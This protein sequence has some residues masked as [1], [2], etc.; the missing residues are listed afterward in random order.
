MDGII[1][2]VCNALKK[3]RIAR[4]MTEYERL[5]SGAATLAEAERFTGGGGDRYRSQSCRFEVVRSPADEPG[6]W[7]DDDGRAPPDGIPDEPFHAGP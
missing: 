6:L 2:F 4:S 1:P 5:P 7:R 3:R